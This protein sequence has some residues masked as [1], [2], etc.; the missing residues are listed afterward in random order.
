LLLEAKME[1]RLPITIL[2]P[3]Y[4]AAPYICQAIDSVLAQSFTD[5]ELLIIND[6][7]TDDTEE[8]IKRYTDKRIRLHTQENKGLIETLN[9]G[10]QIARGTYIARFDA[11]DVCYPDRLKIQY[12]FLINNP[13]YV[14]VGTEAD[15]ADEQGNFIFTYHFRDYEDEEIKGS[16]FRTCP[17]IHSSVMYLRQAVIDAGGYDKNAITFEDHL[18]WRNLSSFGKMKNIR[19]PLMMVRFNPASVTIDEKWRGKE[20][21]EIKQRAIEQGIVSEED[22]AALKDILK[23]QNFAAYKDASYYSMI[24]KKYLWNQY[25]PVKARAHLG[26]AISIMPGKAEPYLLYLFSFLPQRLIEA[27]YT[28]SKKQ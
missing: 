22:A 4:N 17:F 13:G 2:L 28:K 20:F 9:Y 8:L 21:V 19:K 27:V 25:D 23:K 10:L 18:L 6:G 11:D 26:K 16:A 1:S 14:L 5:F 15:Y 3:A 24:G 7:S 12:D